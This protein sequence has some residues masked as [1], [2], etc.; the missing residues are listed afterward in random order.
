MA[1]KKA[2]PKTLQVVLEHTEGRV[3]I[4]WRNLDEESDWD[5]YFVSERNLNRLALEIREHLSKLQALNWE[6][7]DKWDAEQ[8]SDSF[9]VI[10]KELAATGEDLY[11]ELFTGFRGDPQSEQDA[12]EFRKWFEETV[13]PAK[14]GTWRIQ[15]IHTN[16]AKAIVP[17]GL[18][19]TPNKKTEDAAA[20]TY[21]RYKNFWCSS[22]RLACRGAFLE[23]V[24]EIEDRRDGE[25]TKVAVVIERNE[26]QIAKFEHSAI[27]KKTERLHGKR[28]DYIAHDKREFKR[29]ATNQK[30]ND[31]YWYIS[32][33]SD[34]GE[35]SLGGQSLGHHEISLS[36][37]HSAE[38]R[39]IIMLVDGDAV[40]RN[41]RGPQWVK[42][43]LEVGRA[44]LIAVE[45][46]IENPQLKFFGWS[47]LK[48][49]IEAL[50]KHPLIEAMEIARKEFWPRSL[51][52]GVYCNPLHVYLHDYPNDIIDFI[53][54]LMEQSVE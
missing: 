45:T 13:V 19:F 10:L 53:D 40:I 18:V 35:Y 44:G 27:N 16:Y 3:N 15:I 6:G 50:A 29:I 34:G 54:G 23:D 7:F 30:R 47:L 42:S 33:K 8:K 48:F 28:G 46:D 25:R 51:L 39:I 26:D 24:D 22:F 36:Y 17:W 37:Q 21:E 11:Y 12:R 20:P 2:E 9:G 32:L 43:A 1:K 14:E 49:L 41:D 5:P 52:Y 31:V 4:H 38:D